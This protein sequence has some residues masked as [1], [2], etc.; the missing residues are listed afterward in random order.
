MQSIT[1]IM[2]G[3]Y[4]NVPEPNRVSSVYSVSAVL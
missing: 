2:Q 1:I 4:S 3:V